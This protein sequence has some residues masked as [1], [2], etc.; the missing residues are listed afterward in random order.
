MLSM[1][2]AELFTLGYCL[3]FGVAFIAA[4]LAAIWH[5]TRMI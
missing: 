1:E 5:I 3:G 4:L 2:I